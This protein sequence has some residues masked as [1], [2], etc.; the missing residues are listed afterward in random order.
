MT[1]Q[2]PPIRRKDRQITEAESLAIIRRG[3]YGVLG[4]SD[5]QNQPYALPLSY[6]YLDGSIFFHCADKG[7]KIDN[8]S[9]NPKAS[10]CVVMNTQPVYDQSYSTYYESAIAFGQVEKVEEPDKKYEILFALAAKYLPEHMEPAD[11][12]IKKMLRRTAV[13]EMKIR[14]LSGKAKKRPAGGD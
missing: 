8:L 10:F 4:T 12:T 11:L 6:I 9:G 1:N 14:R 7:H 3:E 13:Y 2:W 5:A